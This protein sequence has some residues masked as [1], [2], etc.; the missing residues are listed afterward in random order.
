[1]AQKG[2]NPRNS[3]RYWR[4]FCSLVVLPAA[5]VGED[6]PPT[7]CQNGF[8]PP[9]KLTIQLNREDDFI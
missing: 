1:M 4:E 2:K 9:R 6:T 3:N 8:D 7:L 5:P